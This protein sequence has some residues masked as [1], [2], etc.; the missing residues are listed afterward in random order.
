MT[1]TGLCHLGRSE[2]P[3]LNVK[4]SEQKKIRD[5]SSRSLDETKC[6]PGSELPGFSFLHPGYTSTK[7]FHQVIYLGS[8]GAQQNPPL[9]S[10]SRLCSRQ[11][12]VAGPI[13]M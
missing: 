10:F 7:W 2:Q 9:E 4:T 13:G 1:T 5:L 6:N 8:R 3:V 11:I 12:R